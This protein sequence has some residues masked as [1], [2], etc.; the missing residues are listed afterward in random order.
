M[1]TAYR[2]V[3]ENLVHS[4]IPD[5]CWKGKRK[6]ERQR[7]D[8][9]ITS[10]R[11]P[12]PRH[13]A[14]GSVYIYRSPP[15]IPRIMTRCL[16]LRARVRSGVVR[17][18][19]TSAFFPPTTEAEIN[20]T[21]RKCALRARR[22]IGFRIPLSVSFLFSLS[23]AGFVLG[24]ITNR[25]RGLNRRDASFLRKRASDAGYCALVRSSSVTW[26]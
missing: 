3:N 13:I 4:P 17:R 24:S 26:D 5:R 12:F 14:M 21:R 2:I 9:K 25:D 6:R 15:T 8:A 11:T 22:R 23:F 7:L 1:Y 20:Q 10:Q 16:F 18:V 19:C